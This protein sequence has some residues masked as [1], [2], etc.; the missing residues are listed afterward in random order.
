MLMGPATA[1]YIQLQTPFVKTQLVYGRTE[2]GLGVYS[3][4]GFGAPLVIW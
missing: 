2:A 3:Y 4:L 1:T